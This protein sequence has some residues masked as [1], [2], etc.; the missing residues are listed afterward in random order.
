VK[1]RIALLTLVLAVGGLQTQAAAFFPTTQEVLDKLHERLG[2]LNAVEA[3]V[4]FER[5]P[6][7]TLHLWSKGDRWRQEWVRERNGN[8]T[9]LSAAVGE[10]ERLAASF[11]QR[12]EYPLP[13]LYFWYSPDT[14][15]WLQDQWIS[16]D[17]KSYQFFELK[18]CLVLGAQHSEMY[19][20][21][22]WIHNEDFVPVRMVSWDGLEW[23]WL[24]YYDIG[25]YPLPH[26]C[27]L[28]FPTATTIEMHIS[29]KRINKEVP[30]RLFSEEAFRERFSA[31]SESP[32]RTEFLN[33]LLRRLPHAWQ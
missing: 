15:Q 27:R 21:Q 1:I 2:G 26:E 4:T 33:F 13:L 16:A 9:L 23:Q 30:D 17:V 11:P 14:D 25:N 31:F 22:V 6:Y 24:D 28:K 5:D 32:S 12:S 8:A 18:P 19:R 20:P 3:E 7:L 29:W 10:G